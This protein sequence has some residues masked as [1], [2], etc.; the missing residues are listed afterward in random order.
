MEKLGRVRPDHDPVSPPE[1]SIALAIFFTRVLDEFPIRIFAKL[2]KNQKQV[3]NGRSCTSFINIK[4][5]WVNG[6]FL[7]TIGCQVMGLS[8]INHNFVNFSPIELKF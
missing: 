1:G 7:G 2:M 5:N 3:V 8:L 6:H 4:S